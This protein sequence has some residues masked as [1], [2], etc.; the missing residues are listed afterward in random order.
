[1]N[2][3]KLKMM[4]FMNFCESLSLLSTCKRAKCGAI[5]FSPNFT[6]IQSIG[7]NG[8]P[9]GIRNDSC[10]CIE[11]DCGCVHAEANAIIKLHNINGNIKYTMYS[12]TAPCR[13]CASLIINCKVI[14]TVIYDYLY[15]NNL[16][17][18]LLQESKIKIIQK[19]H[20]LNNH[21]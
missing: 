6:T 7:Y 19:S 3:Q 8:Q 20:W 5:V 11:G 15:R 14:D 21:D 2:R 17:L 18:E 9:S 13:N 16:G 1:M 4:K 10:T 12:T